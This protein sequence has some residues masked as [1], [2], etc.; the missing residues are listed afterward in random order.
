MSTDGEAGAL[1]REWL[2]TASGYECVQTFVRATI[3]RALKAGSISSIAS[4]L[5]LDKIAP[6]EELAEEI[7][8]DFLLFILD[9]AKTKLGGQPLLMA[10]LHTGKYRYF[11]DLLWQRYVWHVKDKGRLKLENP[12]GYLYRRFRELVGTEKLFSTCQNSSGH[13]FYC[14][15]ETKESS[16]VK[17]VNALAD[18]SYA[19]Y[20]MVPEPLQANEKGDFR[21][22]AKWLTATA[23]FFYAVA[24]EKHPRQGYIPVSELV[25][26]LATVMPWLNRP[27]RHIAENDL[28]SDPSS[29]NPIEQFGAEA[30]DDVARLDRLRQSRTI[31]PL[32]EQIIACW[33]R[34]ECCVFAWRL[35]DIPPTFETIAEKLSLQSHNQAYSLFEKTK[36]S[37]KRFC[38]NWP[39]PPL[40]DLAPGVAEFFVN[41]VRQQAKNKCNGS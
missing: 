8:P 14:M 10:Q 15:E 37:L 40:Y 20:P 13:L 30:E 17:T 9:Y 3:E 29:P 25:R 35:Q 33:D 23:E 28:D 22:T 11:L 5:H 16:V 27:T 34:I 31:Y 24:N 39:G 2:E 18:E 32:V 19:N 38:D 4:F 7:I 6:A 36:T 12:R 21:V 1:L 26:Y 41:K